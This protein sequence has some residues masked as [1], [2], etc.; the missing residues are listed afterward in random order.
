MMVDL[1]HYEINKI[2]E[3]YNE[4]MKHPEL[5]YKCKKCSGTGL[6]DFKIGG[7]WSGEFC[8]YCEGKGL[9]YF[10]ELIKE[11]LGTENFY[12]DEVKDDDKR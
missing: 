11:G 7:H 3:E 1:A 5:C 4:K 12:T 8:D 6:K 9:F 10:F 2:S